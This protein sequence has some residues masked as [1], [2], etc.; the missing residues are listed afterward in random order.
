MMVPSSGCS[1]PYSTFI[2]VDLPAPF[3]PSRQWISPGTM[4]RSML[5]LATRDPNRLVMPR[6]WRPLP[7]PAAGAEMAS[8]VTS[9]GRLR[10]GLDLDLARDDV[11]LQGVDLGLEIRRDLGIEIVVGRQ[12]GALVLQRANERAVVEAAVLRG[13]DG[14]QHCDVEALVDTGHDVGAIGLRADTAVGVHPDGI[15]LAAAGLG[16]LQRAF[17]GRTGNREDDVRTL[18]DQTLGGLL[19][20]LDVLE[21]GV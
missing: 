1:S 15:H 20:T 10:L 9:G 18:A 8:A 13:L 7:V 6:S 4:S 17:P 21:G 2:R 16:C 3:S 11:G 14:L 5:S 12:P 19:A